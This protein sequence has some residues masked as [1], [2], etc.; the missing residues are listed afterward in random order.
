MI[1]LPHRKSLIFLCIAAAFAMSV[2]YDTAFAVY[3]ASRLRKLM[4]AGILASLGVAFLLE[5][6]PLKAIRPLAVATWPLHLFTVFFVYLG[7]AFHSRAQFAQV[8]AYTL[9]AYATYAVLPLLLV[10]DRR[11]FDAFVA[12]IALL[13]GVLAVPSFFGSMGYGSFLGIPLSTKVFYANFSGIVA[14]GGV[15]EHGEGH[16]L[17]MAAGMLC[18]LYFIR[19][20]DSSTLMRNLFGGCFCLCLVG[21]VISQGR[22][23]ILGFTIAVAFVLLPEVFRRSRLLFFGTLAFTLLFPFVILPQLSSVPGVSRYLR[24][25]KGLSGARRCLGLRAR[26]CP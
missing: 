18:C 16:A 21:L 5:R 6:Y 10:L 15:F 20:S 24:L 26:P 7:L 14:S 8:I 4:A 17:Q 3:F 2:L 19:K 23:A 12:M 11:R 22:A 1:L 25:E 13:S 9:V